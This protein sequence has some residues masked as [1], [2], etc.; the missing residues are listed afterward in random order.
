[1]NA[2]EPL[3]EILQLEGGEFGVAF[4]DYLV[5][6]KNSAEPLGPV[7]EEAWLLLTMLLDIEMEGFVDLFYQLYSLRECS[8]VQAGLQKL[9]LHRLA[10]LFGEAFSI[11]IDGNADITEEQYRQIDWENG[12]RWP[13]FDAIGEEI[14]AEG[15]EIYLIGDRVE[16]YVKAHLK[17]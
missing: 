3:S 7:E 8:I 6:R 1:V 15:S 17:G 14:L 13:R 12:G 2:P 9:G 5:A 10:R 4:Y 16:Q 11:Y